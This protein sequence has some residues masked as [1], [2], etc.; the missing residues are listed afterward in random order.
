MPLIPSR[1]LLLLPVAV[2]ALKK[3]LRKQWFAS[4]LFT[5]WIDELAPRGSQHNCY[6]EGEADP[7]E[8]HTDVVVEV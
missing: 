7:R 1:T 2:L 6:I 4:P 5:W 8:V 3:Y